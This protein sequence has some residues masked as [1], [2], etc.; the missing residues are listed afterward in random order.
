MYVTNYCTTEPLIKGLGQKTDKQTRAVNRAI[1]KDKELTDE[2]LYD[3][4][5][6]ARRVE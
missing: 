5:E 4:A 2:N 1:C 6:W 3:A